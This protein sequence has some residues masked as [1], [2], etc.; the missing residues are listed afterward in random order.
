MLNVYLYFPNNYLDN[1]LAQRYLQLKKT[2][3]I[4]DLTAPSSGGGSKFKQKSLI[5]TSGSK[6]FLFL[7]NIIIKVE[8][9]DY[10]EE[11]ALFLLSTVD[12]LLSTSKNI[13]SEKEKEQ[14]LEK[15]LLQLV[16][17]ESVKEEEDKVIIDILKKL[18]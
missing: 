16:I 13:Y 12:S 14:K 11:E 15:L 18:L 1:W 5:K 2:E 9:K 10:N 4:I 17:D 3:V 8:K 6:I 7:E